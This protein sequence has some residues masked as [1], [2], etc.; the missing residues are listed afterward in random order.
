MLCA[1]LPSRASGGLKDSL[2][3]RGSYPC[4]RRDVFDRSA[5]YAANGPEPAQQGGLLRLAYTGHLVQDRFADSPLPQ[6]AVVRYGK[7]VRFVAKPR[8]DHKRLR[9][10]RKEHVGTSVVENDKLLLLCEADRRNVS[11]AEFGEKRP[12]CAELGNATVADV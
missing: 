6:A 12:G 2:C 9:I 4:R 10:A 7:A 8:D 1:F 11:Y 3:R 5:G